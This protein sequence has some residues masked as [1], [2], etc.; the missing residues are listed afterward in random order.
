[1]S[2]AGNLL[3]MGAE[4]RQLV[5]GLIDSFKSTRSKRDSP[6]AVTLRAR[7]PHYRPLSGVIKYSTYQTH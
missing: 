3:D 7:V 2:I 5:F 4:D 1:V 6:R